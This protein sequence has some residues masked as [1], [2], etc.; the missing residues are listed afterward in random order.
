M[1]TIVPAIAALLAASAAMHAAAMQADDAGFPCLIE[2]NEVI[3]LGSSAKGIIE[4]IEVERGDRVKKGQTVARLESGVERAAL[5]LAE[6]RAVN[7]APVRSTEARLAFEA[8]RAQRARELFAEEVMAD[9]TLDEIE[10]D[11]AM[12]EASLAEAQSNQNLARLE[13]RRMREVLAQRVIKSPIDGVVVDV[14]LSE[15]EFTHEQA[16]LMTVAEIDPL[17][18]ET[19]LPVSL[20]GSVETG[21]QATIRPASPIGGVLQA[22]ID[23]VDPVIDAASGTFG[24]VLLVPNPDGALP[25]GLR[26]R[27]DLSVSG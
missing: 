8:R 20:Y 14:H 3:A 5:A 26:C 13:L 16:P 18:I 17:R 24:V 19:F 22:K 23:V 10:T 15:G 4:K 27:L 1:K 11:R 2:A 12:A 7:D 9:T 25:A 6:A 21:D